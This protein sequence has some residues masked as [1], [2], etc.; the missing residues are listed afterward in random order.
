MQTLLQDIRFALRQLLRAPA[1]AI[2]AIVTLALSI[3]LATAV[4]SVLD[5]TIIRP[6]P[7]H[8]PDEIVRLVT[9]SPQGYTQPASWPQYL[10]WRNQ[11]STLSAI[12]GYESSS[13]NLES[14][15]GASP[16]RA[17]YT[18]DS[19]FD[20]FG[21]PPVLGRTFRPG[22]DQSGHNDV[23]IL[24]YELW[25]QSFGGRLDVIGS[26]LKV[27]GIPN[28]V[29]GVMPAGFRF[30]LTAS[31][32]LYRPFH[33]AQSLINGR[34]SHI[35]PI[36]GRLKPGVTSLQAQA[37]IQHVFDNLGR[38]YPDEAGRRIKLITVAEMS[39][40]SSAAPLRV[41]TLAVFGVL[42]I[43][44]VNI[45]GLLLARGLRRQRELGLRSA[46]GAGRGRLVRQMLT[47]SAVLSLAGSACGILL[48]AILLRILRQLLI[49]SLARGAD[50]Q[51]NLPVLIATI[52]IALLTGLG[53]G[54]LPALQS[55]RTSP[56]LAL[57]SG[58]GAGF[59]RRQNHLRFGLITLQ[60][61]IA[62]GLIVCSG[63]LLRNLGN[64]RNTDLGFSPE[65]LLTDDIFLSPAEYQGRSML[66][67]FY[68]P[69]LERVSSIPGVT[70]AG[71]TNLLPVQDSG[72]NSDIHIVGKP[73][74]PDNKAYLAENRVI[75]P[76]TLETY[77]AH[78]LQGRMLDP[79]LDRSDVSLSSVVNETFVNKFFS[80][81]E[82]PVG[83]QIDWSG[84][85]VNIVGV[86]SD[87][88]QDL[89][90]PTLAEMDIPA[91]QIPSAYS[92]DILTHMTLVIRTTGDPILITSAVRR[93]MY[94][95]DPTVPFRAPLTMKQVITETLTFE[96]L[97]SWLFGIFASL[98][99][100]LSLVG[101][102]G[103]VHLEVELRTRDI[104]VRMALG[105]T[106]G[107]IFRQILIRVGSLM[108]GGIILGWALTLGLQK[109][110]QSVIE[111]HPAH[112]AVLL[113]ALTVTFIIIGMAASLLPA[114]RA[115]TIDPIR[116]LRSE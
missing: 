103:M 79:S 42:V 21:V 39:L 31:N 67:N 35:L 74:T 90:Q 30:P 96:R 109:V 32:A 38:T 53:A 3:G 108:L 58:G 62:L 105:S 59:S 46:V 6:L 75:T 80:P 94:A 89:T 5:A 40:G 45:A 77:G 55:S 52:F 99:V 43:G 106:R 85:H 107:R 115:A 18:T 26:T 56:Y 64:L 112:N 60:I 113:A 111:I 47:E 11:I 114:W 8:N 9:Y 97:E 37:D 101:I 49:H 22:E 7:Y 65:H 48:A 33:L 82:N 81:G 44:C 63:L 1:F 87:L 72:F 27:D 51:L 98:A 61:S 116:A 84:T 50:V 24:S 16:V 25:Q 104:G 28:I 2:V 88:R 13:A 92:T 93:A 70:S 66:T 34:G 29:V 57:R 36:I 95:T 69:L 71:I 102:Y 15:S 41:L 83:R 17:I 91:D 68:G 76:G 20:I 110:L 78:L 73:P 14:G 54:A 100:V 23:V 12:A 19:F 10:D 4:F 86:T